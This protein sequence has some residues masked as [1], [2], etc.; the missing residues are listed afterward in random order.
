VLVWQQ[1]SLISKMRQPEGY[2]PSIKRAARHSHSVTTGRAMPSDTDMPLMLPR[3]K[4]T[5]SLADEAA[6]QE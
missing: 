6:E 1:L 2:V 3:R 5:V 4:S